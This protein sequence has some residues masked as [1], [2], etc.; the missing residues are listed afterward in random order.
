MLS[1]VV[2]MPNT[3]SGKGCLILEPSLQ[4]HSAFPNL[5]VALSSM[6]SLST[7]SFE[8]EPF[9][10]LAIFPNIYFPLNT[11][12]LKIVDVHSTSPKSLHIPHRPLGVP[13]ISAILQGWDV[14]LVSYIVRVRTFL[15]LPLMYSY[16]IG[17]FSMGQ[18]ANMEILKIMKYIYLNDTFRK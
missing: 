14:L 9:S 13:L 17:H 2:A 10:A 11:R 3:H 16:Y 8:L 7:C 12:T 5:T 18:R 15:K 6:A 1:H 4:S